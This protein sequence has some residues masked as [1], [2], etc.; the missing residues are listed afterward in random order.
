MSW[1]AWEPGLEPR[2]LCATFKDKETLFRRAFEAY[3]DL[4]RAT[5][6][7]GLSG[8]ASIEAWTDVQARL[9]MDDPDRKGCLIVNTIAEREAHSPETHALAKARMDEIRAFFMRNVD[10]AIRN[11]DL[12]AQADVAVLSDSLVGT[13][14]A[15][16]MLGRA[17]ADRSVIRNVADR[18]IATLGDAVIAARSPD[19]SADRL[20]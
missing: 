10:Q 12:P 2:N 19:S 8:R 16:M 9:A 3:A 17:G 15:L 4:F 13:V 14:V 5:L 20:G 6:P 18:A 7:A 1:D 11:G